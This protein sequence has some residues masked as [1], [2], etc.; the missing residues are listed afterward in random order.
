MDP[1]I[2]RYNLE[3]YANLEN[4]VAEL[5]ERISGILLQRLIHVI[6]VWC[7][8]FERTE[9]GDT[10]RETVLRDITNKR[11]GDKHKHEKV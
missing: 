9:D 11:R 5:D 3:G 4:W 7:A 2:D 1:Q 8:E 6:Q 10:R